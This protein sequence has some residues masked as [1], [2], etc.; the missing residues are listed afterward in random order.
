MS[1]ALPIYGG[2]CKARLSRQSR[3][4]YTPMRGRDD[5]KTLEI[6]DRVRGAKSVHQMSRADPVDTY[7]ETF[8]TVVGEVEDS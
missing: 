2:V 7:D 6:K 3:V 8:L 1:Y 4:E 5:Y